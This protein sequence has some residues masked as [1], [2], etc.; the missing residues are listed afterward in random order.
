MGV[1]SPGDGGSDHGGPG[2]FE[3]CVFVRALCV[4]CVVRVY[5]LFAMR[6]LLCVGYVIQI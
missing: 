4:W 3:V 5:V 6:D 2:P 1:S